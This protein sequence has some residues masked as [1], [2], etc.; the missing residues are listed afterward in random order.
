MNKNRFRLLKALFAFV[1]LPL[2]PACF[3][4]RAGD[5]SEVRAE[6]AEPDVLDLQGQSDAGDFVPARVLR[7]QGHL[8]FH[9]I[10]Q[11]VVLPLELSIALY[12]NAGLVLSTDETKLLVASSA[13]TNLLVLDADTLTILDVIPTSASIDNLQVVDEGRFVVAWATFGRRSKSGSK[14]RQARDLLILDRSDFSLKHTVSVG[15]N[16]GAVADVSQGRVLVS[17]VQS[18]TIALVDLDKGEVISQQSTAN[19]KFS[20]GDVA[21]RPDSKIAM[22]SGGVFRQQM[23]GGP[24]TQS[25]ATGSQ[26][27]LLD[28]LDPANHARM[29]FFPKLQHPRGLLFHP[30]GRHVFV[31]DDQQ[32]ALVILDWV[33]RRT[34]ETIAL[35]DA[36]EDLGFF[37]GGQRLWIRHSGA[38]MLSVVDLENGRIKEVTLPNVAMT[39]PVF[40]PDGEVFYV[41][42]AMPSVI[43]VISVETLKLVDEIELPIFPHQLQITRDGKRL[44]AA[45]GAGINVIRVE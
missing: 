2:S 6:T 23:L 14:Y 36:P 1:A 15:E 31:A 40:S 27:L 37:P 42:T 7:T 28:P 30:N 12:F 21:V 32:N 33:A 18:E 4:T 26:V 5:V 29:T 45:L 19:E 22:V 16:I 10:R 20:P 11:S 41:G 3:E 17:A 38:P 13:R 9:T 44:F 39:Q 8:R 43:A 34:Q 35:A 25:R 24:Q